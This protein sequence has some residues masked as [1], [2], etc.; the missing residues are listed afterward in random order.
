MDPDDRNFWFKLKHMIL[1]TKDVLC[2]TGLD[3]DKVCPLC[4]SEP[5]SHSHL[6]IYC[7]HT[8]VA[9]NLVEHL[10]KIYTGNK[11]FHLSDPM[12]ILGQNLKLVESIIV[13][14]MLRQIWIIRCLLVF[15]NYASPV[16]VDITT[17]FKR[18]LKTFL[19][20]EQKRMDGK[21]IEACYTWNKALCFVE[22]NTLKFAF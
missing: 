19:L 22:N 2:K 20:S 4:N 17:Q 16:D 21:K 14:K 15:Q 6:F 9:W 11:Y 1:P 5:E 7:S 13:V 18:C 8:W 12:R 10:L 3:I